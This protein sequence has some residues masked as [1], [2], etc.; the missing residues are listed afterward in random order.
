[1]SLQR[2]E[3]K[4]IL[5]LCSA[6]VIIDLKSAIKELIENSI[7]SQANYIGIFPF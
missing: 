5:Q 7:D 2:I 6:Q 1:M 4:S 3:G